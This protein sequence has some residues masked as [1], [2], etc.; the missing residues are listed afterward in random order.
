MRRVYYYLAYKFACWKRQRDLKEYAKI[1]RDLANLREK[2]NRLQS[3]A[4]S[5]EE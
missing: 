3:S 5:E 1:E 2:V 4:E